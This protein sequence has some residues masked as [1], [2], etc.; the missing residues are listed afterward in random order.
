[1]VLGQPNRL[2][3]DE[4]YANDNKNTPLGAGVR[5]RVAI[6]TWYSLSRRH[7]RRRRHG[8]LFRTDAVGCRCTGHCPIRH[9]RC[10]HLGDSAYLAHPVW[11]VGFWILPAV[12]LR[13]V[14]DFMPGYLQVSGWIPAIL[15][16]LVLMLIGMVTSGSVKKFRRA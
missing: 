15:G 8:A 13:L 16:S 6:D 14:S 7:A 9:P 12:A 5:L 4:K 2:P 1:M 11:I 3:G 10:E